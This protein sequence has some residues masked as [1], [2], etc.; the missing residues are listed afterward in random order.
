MLK[1]QFLLSYYPSNLKGDNLEHRDM[2]KLNFIYK[3]LLC[4]TSH[5]EQI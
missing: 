5:F 2:S 4:V 3:P 1:D